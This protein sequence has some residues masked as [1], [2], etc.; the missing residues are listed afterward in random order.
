[1]ITTEKAVLM[2]LP[3]G[4]KLIAKGSVG[5]VYDKTEDKR[6]ES[7]DISLVS[8]DGFERV[9]TAFDFEEGR[10]LNL[11]VYDEKHEN[12]SSIIDLGRCEPDVPSLL[13]E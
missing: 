12:P 9:V 6:W 7:V 3:D 10:G 5:G 4:S 2:I 13:N 1:M 8:P 11:C